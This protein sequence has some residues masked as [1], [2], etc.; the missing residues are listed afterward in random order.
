MKLPA[1]LALAVCL[2]PLAGSAQTIYRCRGN[3]YTRIPCPDGRPLE[4]F[5]THSA[6]QRAEA[7]RILAEE[8]KRAQETEHERLKRETSIK[9]PA[10][11]SPKATPVATAASA[12]KKAAPK[13]KPQKA[14]P[15]P[16][17]DFVAAVP[18]APKP[19]AQPH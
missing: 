9:P 7:R 12:P 18:V 13:K 19:S 3:E 15:D 16:D 17:R 5:D 8:E 14:E 6:A 11:S 4:A 1:T 2:I 10:A